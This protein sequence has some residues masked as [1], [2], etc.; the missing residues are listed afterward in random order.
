MRAAGQVDA[1][2]RAQLAAVDHAAAHIGSV[3][4]F[5]LEFHGPSASSRVSPGS[6][7]ARQVGLGQAHLVRV[8]GHV[9][10]GQ[11]ESRALPS[12]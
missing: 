2:V 9:A 4:G 5:D 7:V 11:G 1:L 3:G 8:A 12:G 10:A 6:H